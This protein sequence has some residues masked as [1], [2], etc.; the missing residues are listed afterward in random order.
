MRT[1]PATM[2]TGP[3]ASG[4][5]PSACSFLNSSTCSG[6]NWHAGDV[7]GFGAKG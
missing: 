6:V 5:L 4:S 7:M 3:P 2:N 1:K